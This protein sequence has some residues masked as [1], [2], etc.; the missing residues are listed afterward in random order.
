[1]ADGDTKATKLGTKLR[2]RCT[3]ELDVWI[4]RPAG[5]EH[6]DDFLQFIIEENSCPGT[7]SVGMAIE[8]AIER[9]DATSTCWACPSGENKI[10]S[11]ERDVEEPSDD[12]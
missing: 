7:G 4:P 2:V 5:I 8:K 10:L 11:I 6:T 9:G 3:V 12:A 1:M